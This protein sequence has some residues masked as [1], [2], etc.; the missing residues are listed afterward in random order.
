MPCNEML[1]R[2]FINLIRLSPKT[3]TPTSAQAN[4]NLAQKLVDMLQNNEKDLSTTPPKVKPVVR[5][6]SLTSIGSRTS[7]SKSP[8]SVTTTPSS[9]SASGQQREMQHAFEL[10]LHD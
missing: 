5:S 9:T 2:P 7:S 6:P 8:G 10:S 4:P 1:C 3:Q